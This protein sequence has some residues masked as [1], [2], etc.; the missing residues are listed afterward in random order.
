MKFKK[1]LVTGASGQLGNYVVPALQDAGYLVTGFDKVPYPAGFANAERRVPF[2]QGDLGNLGDCLR[3]LLLS[4]ADAVVSLGAIRSCSELQPPYAK[5]YDLKHEQTGA[6]FSQR[7][8]EETTMEVNTM[9]TYT[10]MDAIRR[11]GKATRVIHASSFF[12]LGLGFRLSGTPYIPPY[13][14]MDENTPLEPEDSYSLSKVLGEE[15]LKSFARA[16]GIESIAM[17]LLGVYYPDNEFSRRQHRFNIQA[18]PTDKREHGYPNNSTYQYV[19]ARDIANF[20]L[21]GL[22]ADMKNTFEPYFLATDTKYTQP[23]SEVIRLS[24]PLLEDMADDVAGTDG[25]ISIEKARK[26]LGY[27]P[28]YSWRDGKQNLEN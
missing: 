24:W 18:E 21:L 26:E 17:R 25:I 22:E 19:D 9:G 14:P 20:V 7:W 2:V 13:L 10:L 6:R 12:V 3:A 23:T 1:I 5:D 28:A 27:E 11:S 4:E 8:P 16:Y 15:I